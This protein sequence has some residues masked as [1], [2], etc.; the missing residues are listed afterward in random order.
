MRRLRRFLFAVASTALT[1]A[2]IVATVCVL[3]LGTPAG[4]G[5]IRQQTE[6]VVARVLGADF[7]AILGAQTIALT[8]DGTLAIRW[9]DVTLIRRDAT[10]PASR[11][12]SIKVGIAVPPLFGG[13]LEFDRIEIDG[14]E[15]DLTG[16]RLRGRAEPPVAAL[17]AAETELPRSIHQRFAE[18]VAAVEVQL[19]A[20]HRL[21]IDRVVLRDIALTVPVGADGDPFVADIVRARFQLAD[22]AALALSAEIRVDGISVPF[23]ASAR[24]NDQA[25]HLDRA[26][27]SL[28]PVP[29]GALIPP[30]S[31]EDRLD[32]RPFATDAPGT[33]RFA[34]TTPEGETLRRAELSVDLGRGALQA[35]RGHTTLEKA[36]LGL[37]YVEGE[38]ALA[39]EDTSLF[40]DGFV[41]GI[42]GRAVAVHDAA[43]GAFNGF[44]FA[45]QSRDM[46]STIGAPAGEA[47]D[48]NV[49]VE[50]RHD[51][52]GKELRLDKL[53]LATGG[54][55]LGGDAVLRY[56]AA[57]AMTTL[58]LDASD[59]KAGN[60]KA[61][62]PFNVA[63]NTRRWVLDRVG[64]DGGVTGGRIAIAVRKD[65]LDEAF[66]PEKS[67]RPEELVIDL[68]LDGAAI[69]T[70][71]DLPRLTGARGTV[72]TRGGDTTVALETASVEGFGKVAVAPSTVTFARAAE[73]AVQDVDGRLAIA[74]SGDL[75]ELLAIAAREPINALRTLPLTPGDTS[76]TATVKAELG[77][78]LGDAI[79]RDRQFSGWKVDAVLDDAAVAVPVEGRRLAALTGPIAITPGAASGNI[80]GTVD[81]IP[82]TIAFH[83]PFGMKPEGTRKLEVDLA[84]T[85]NTVAEVL[86]SL[87]DI[88]T[89][90]IAAKI[91]QGADASLRAEVELDDAALTLPWIGWRKG[92][93]VAAALA[94]DI[95]TVEG[96][97][98]LRNVS[99]KGEGFSASGEVEADGEGVRSAT[100]G[101]V[102]LN[103]GDDIDVE[104][105][106]VANGFSIRV[107]G[108]RF[109]A[110]PFLADLKAN[111]G[112]KAENAGGRS[113]RQID[114]GIAV[115]RLTGF[116]GEE[117]AGFQLNYAGSAGEIA[118]LAISG[119]SRGGAFTADLSPRGEERSIVV[120][121]PD[122]GSLADF[123]GIYGRME[124]GAVTLDLIGSSRRGYRGTLKAENFTLV[125]E[126]RLSNLVG[127]APSP[128]QSSLSQALGTDLRTERAFFDHA[129]VNIGYGRGGLAVSDGIIRGPVFGSSFA[130][131][132]YDLRN[133]IDITGSFMPAYGINRIFGAIPVVG[134]ILGNGNEGGLIGITYRLDGEFSSPTLTV[135][136]ISAIAPGIF[137]NIFA[138]Q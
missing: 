66:A 32:R 123:A 42:D 129:S 111:L 72:A 34:L 113:R 103:P 92:K 64:D 81:G 83:R 6:T 127:S 137:R 15:I 89:G 135:N 35:G 88:L 128:D 65:R 39:L 38:D 63:V 67:P 125:D 105:Q 23:S 16:G 118:A 99:L 93:G 112:A 49:I 22:S 45:L 136:P 51:I 30:G 97:T 31:P 5:L 107:D 126:P 86:P 69:E 10:L 101:D 104:V 17:P 130:G 78:L 110:R 95:A 119:S 73:E 7:R 108:K 21:G 61:F 14:A 47:L 124:G 55:A 84:M 33:L 85:G 134:Q 62:W 132:V 100:L 68:A 109:D 40:F 36:R 90:P 37:A 56:G 53:V 122:A 59:L 46:T 94:F 115:D 18:S 138:Y 102:A 48:A 27:V 19:A 77:F 11:V 76:G 80:D 28:G 20:L 26:S 52:A 116:G 60:V 41:M 75:P 71:G 98:A 70:V 133:R 1:F 74:L 12:A 58:T 79:A 9:S 87:S 25:A 44:D 3:A 91:V 2:I 114:V 120:R 50:G 117:I 8:E 96:R 106:R 29:L 4:Q 24:F 13:R 54:G 131:T 82:A 57:D 121:T 43:D